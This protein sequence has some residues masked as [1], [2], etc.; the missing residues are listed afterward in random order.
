MNRTLRRFG[1]TLACLVSLLAGGLFSAS[2]ANAETGRVNLHM[3]GMGPLPLAGEVSVDWQFARPF[4]LE[5]RAGGGVLSDFGQNEQGI[6]YSTVGARIRFLDDES[7]YV[8]EGGSIAGHLWV[9]PHVGLFVTSATAGLLVDASVGYDFSVVDPVSIGPFVR[10]GLGIGGAD[11]AAFFAGGLE[12]SVEIDPLRRP[13]RDTD[14]DGVFD[15]TDV[16]PSSAPGAQVDSRGCGDDDRDTV[17]NDADLCP[18]TP[19]G[20]PVDVRGCI[21]LP[22]R[23]VLDGIEFEHDSA[24]ILP[25]SERML[26]QAAQALRDN[27]RVRIEISGHTDD[28]GVP[29]YNHQLSLARAT[30]VRD[31]LVRAGIA[32]RRLEVAGYGSQHPRVPNVDD[33]SRARNRRIEFRQ[34]E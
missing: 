17:T 7:G 5:L 14:G 1:V 31:W 10:A 26:L 12:V 33:A 8:N 3:A 4:A 18:N 30:A 24:Q 25:V 27:P 23:L 20:V 16:C 2:P 9:A 29:A 22:P 34:I 11:M 15:D 28:V 19:S 21:V 32:E 13:R 6:F